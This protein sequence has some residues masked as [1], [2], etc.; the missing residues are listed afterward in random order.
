[1]AFLLWTE[2]ARQIILLPYKLYFFLESTKKVHSKGCKLH[3]DG[4]FCRVGRICRGRTVD[5]G[6]SLRSTD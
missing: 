4:V 6:R 5:K 3:F 1:M 2:E